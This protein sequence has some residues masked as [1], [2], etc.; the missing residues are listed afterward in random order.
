MCEKNYFRAENTRFCRTAKRR[1]MNCYCVQNRNQNKHNFLPK[2]CETI[3]V[4]ST[5]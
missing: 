5:S 2:I 3:I 1:F 4:Q